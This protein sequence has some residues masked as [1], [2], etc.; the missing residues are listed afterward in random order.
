MAY[1]CPRCGGAVQRQ[2]SN[3]A[4]LAGGLAGA[5]IAGAFGNFGCKQCGTIK[6]SEF[7]PEV[8]RRMTIGSISL[9]GTA[10][11]LI[12]GVLVLLTYLR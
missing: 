11:V 12:I 1:E 2:V 10:V 8:R 3:A 7:P 4:G 6:K 9:V 5:M